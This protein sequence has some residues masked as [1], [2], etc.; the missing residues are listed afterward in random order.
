MLDEL[1]PNLWE[2]RLERLADFPD[3]QTAAEAGIPGFEVDT[4][5]TQKRQAAACPATLGWFKM[6]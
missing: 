2:H 1:A 6:T 5:R 4:Y 3:V